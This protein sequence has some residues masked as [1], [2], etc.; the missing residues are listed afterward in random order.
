MRTALL[1]YVVAK[2]MECSCANALC[3]LRNAAGIDSSSNSQTEWKPA[4]TAARYG[5]LLHAVGADM[6][7]SS[8]CNLWS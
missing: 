1:F 8:T 5:V 3:R 7:L 2:V 4:V 6:C